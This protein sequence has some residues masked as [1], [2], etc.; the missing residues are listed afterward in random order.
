MTDKT[1]AMSDAEALALL[2]D[3]LSWNWLD[4]DAPDDSGHLAA[5]EYIRSI[6][7]SPDRRAQPGE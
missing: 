2:K 7:R 5:I 6:P 4:D 3:A 1:E